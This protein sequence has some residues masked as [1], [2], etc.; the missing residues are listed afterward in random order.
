MT[1]PV[2]DDII[3]PIT[4]R[5]K[6]VS[7]GCVPAAQHGEVRTLFETSMVPCVWWG[8]VFLGLH[9]HS[10]LLK[11]CGSA[12][13]HVPSYLQ[14]QGRL[15]MIND[16]E[17]SMECIWR[18]KSLTLDVGCLAKSGYDAACE[19]DSEPSRDAVEW[20]ANG[21]SHKV[22]RHGYRAVVSAWGRRIG[23]IITICEQTRK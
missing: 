11:D 12:R 21:F 4:R 1:T 15:S 18:C 10:P 3:P 19:N 17:W 13:F 5:Q 20:L 14:P 6:Y 22:P 2:F 8:Q 9:G 16:H 7:P 23:R